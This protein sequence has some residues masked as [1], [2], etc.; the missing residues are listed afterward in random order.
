MFCYTL[1]ELLG[2]DTA[3]HYAD[4]ADYE[5]IGNVG[6]KHFAAG[7]STVVERRFSTVNDYNV[8]Y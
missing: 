1:Q 6:H 3:L 5:R 8:K 4:H 7:L 2:M